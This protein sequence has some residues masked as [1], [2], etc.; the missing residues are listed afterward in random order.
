MVGSDQW[1]V[2]EI[3]YRILHK[4][5]G[6]RTQIPVR[7]KT[8]DRLWV[9]VERSSGEKILIISP[10]I[11]SVVVSQ[12]QQK[13]L[14]R[15]GHCPGA[16]QSRLLHLS[17]LMLTFSCPD[18]VIFCPVTGPADWGPLQVQWHG[19]TTNPACV[20]FNDDNKSPLLT[21]RNQSENIFLSSVLLKGRQCSL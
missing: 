8:R 6:E 13:R 14:G 17:Y 4:Q 18:L 2:P 11:K 19:P 12:V 7:Y 16:L 10:R 3:R 9:S 15:P 21:C 5:R 1:S 20:N